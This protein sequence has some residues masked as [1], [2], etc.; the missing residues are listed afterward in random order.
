MNLGNGV[1]DLCIL[2]P[3]AR[4]GGGVIDVAFQVSSASCYGDVTEAV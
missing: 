1:L 3:R 2:D 4:V